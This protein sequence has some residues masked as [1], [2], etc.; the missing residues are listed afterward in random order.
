MH[1]TGAD[2]PLYL[3]NYKKAVFSCWL[4]LVLNF[5]C[6]SKKSVAGVSIKRMHPAPAIPLIR[7]SIQKISASSGWPGLS[8]RTTLPKAQ[9]LEPVNP[10]SSSW[11]ESCIPLP[12]ATGSM[13]SMREPAGRYGLLTHFMKV[14]EGEFVAA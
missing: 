5:G 8:T 2:H 14:A 12:P 1:G 4:L 10:I 6:R 9:D 3:A 7:I 13:R 11:M